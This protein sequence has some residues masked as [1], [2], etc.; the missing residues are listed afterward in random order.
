MEF[1]IDRKLTFRPIKEPNTEVPFGVRSVGHYQV[2][3][4][5]TGIDAVK[6]FI[7]FFWCIEGR[8]LFFHNQRKFMLKKQQIFLYLPGDCHIVRTNNDLWNYRW[9]TIDGRYHMEIV[10]GFGLE[11]NVYNSGPCPEELFIKLENEIHDISPYGQRLAC[12]T[13]FSILAQACGRRP[14]ATLSDRIVEN[15]VN[16]INQQYQKHDLDINHIADTMGMHRTTLSKLFK[17]KMGISP[18][19]YLISVRVRKA[20]SMLKESNLN[21]TEIAAMTGYDD[22]NYFTKV[23]KKATGMTPKQFREQ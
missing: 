10:S 23:I 11:R 5:Y 7:Q 12:T 1:T 18:V 4:G 3:K 15:F 6:N 8:G 21:I 19:D 17:K 14:I 22:S 9:L 20:L 2:C 16:V 13:A